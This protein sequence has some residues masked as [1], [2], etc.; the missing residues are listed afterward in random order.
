MVSVLISAVCGIGVAG[1][2]ASRTVE[3]ITYLVILM[4]SVVLHE[5]A[6]AVAV[7]A[8]GGR[9]RQMR[10]GFG[11]RLTPA[12]SMLDVR[13]LLVAGHVSYTPPKDATRPQL[14]AI[15]AA[16]IVMHLLFVMAALALGPGQWPVW[17]IDLLVVN[18]MFLA[19][20]L[21]PMVGGFTSTVGGMNDGAKLMAILRGAPVQP[22]VVATNYAALIAAYNAG[23]LG[24]MNGALVNFSVEGSTSVRRDV[25]G[26]LLAAGRFR[27]AAEVAST[28]P[29]GTAQAMAVDTIYGRAVLF[30]L[31]SGEPWVT[32]MFVTAAVT[33]VEASVARCPADAPAEVRADVSLP[34]ALVRVVQRRYA[35]ADASAEGWLSVVASPELRA[36]A[37]ATRG[38][39]ALGMGQVARARQYLA[40]AGPNTGSDPVVGALAAQLAALP[41]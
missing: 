27:D 7:R 6:H 2:R 12:T 18:L 15:S 26:A 23:G 21:L 36:R 24:A 17:R 13:P 19:S 41:V 39:A 28:I 29:H 40:Q 3:V 8:V 38:L 34:L 5:C 9:M 20:N 4:V 31:I 37:Y 30:A 35:E 11:P 33:A 32:D 1:D 25:A 10:L 22:P 14:F 16:G